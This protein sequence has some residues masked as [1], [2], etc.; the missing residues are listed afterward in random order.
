[1]PHSSQVQMEGEASTLPLLIEVGR[2]AV[3]SVVFGW[4][5]CPFLDPLLSWLAFL[6]VF[7]FPFLSVLLVF[8]DWVLASP[9]PSPG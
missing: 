7:S 3:L 4:R 5:G 8:L 6:G 1:M 9:E 2:A